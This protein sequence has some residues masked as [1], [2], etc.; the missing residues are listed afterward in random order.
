LRK[1]QGL[2]PEIEVYMVEGGQRILEVLDGR[3]TLLL[4][5]AI[6]AGTRPGTIHRFE[7]PDK[8]VE[9]LRPGSTHDLRPAEALQLAAALGIAPPRVMVFGM[10]VESLDPQ[11]GLSPAVTAA[12]PQL[13]RCLVEELEANPIVIANSP[14]PVGEEH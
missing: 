10:E 7:W 4:V 6:A 12:V 11:A 2:P 13:V 14:E 9:A 8:R 3:G 1:R 5:D